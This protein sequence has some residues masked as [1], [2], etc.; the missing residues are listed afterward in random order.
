ML[1]EKEPENLT[2]RQFLVG[3][4][5]LV[6]EV[7][8]FGC[9]S[10][11]FAPPVMP[12]I[13]SPSPEP[14]ATLFPEKMSQSADGVEEKSLDKEAKE[15]VFNIKIREG[16][17]LSSIL[18][19]YGID[20]QNIENHNSE[21]VTIKMPLETYELPYKKLCLPMVGMSITPWKEEWNL[22]ELGY[23]DLVAYT[24]LF[25]YS[26]F[27]HT[28]ERNSDIGTFAGL[29]SIQTGDCFYLSRTWMGEDGDWIEAEV[30]DI[31]KVYRTEEEIA[32]T[33][34]S[35]SQLLSFTTCFVESDNS[36]ARIIVLAKVI[37]YNAKGP[38]PRDAIVQGKA[39]II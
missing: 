20:E 38:T 1:K 24:T 33:N 10:E 31:V 8:L 7:L 5:A 11:K 19:F 14:T 13:E 25:P 16:E 29:R 22:G 39:G 21:E 12:E 6:G 9:Q 3:S 27:G 34:R 26:F 35:N 18:S 28:S 32:V 4:V 30:I 2:R 15:D 17:S 36:D 23:G 37:N